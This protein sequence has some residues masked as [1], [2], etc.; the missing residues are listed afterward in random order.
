MHFMIEHEHCVLVDMGN[1]QDFGE[2]FGNPL[3]P[4][5]IQ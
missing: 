1:F 4:L 3:L 2:I 5:Q